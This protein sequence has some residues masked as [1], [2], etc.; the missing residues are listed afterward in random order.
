[1]KKI[2]CVVDNTVQRSSQFWGEHGLSFLIETDQG[3]A[4]FD[5]GQ[6]GSVLLH[7]LDVIGGSQKEIS[8]V[9]LSH[10]HIDHTGGLEAFLEQEGRLPL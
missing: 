3:C 7:N 1:M 10:A 9:V 4:L 6:S 2:T 5:T 8:A